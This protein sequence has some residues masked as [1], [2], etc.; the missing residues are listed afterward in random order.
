MVGLLRQRRKQERRQPANDVGVVLSVV[1]VRG[2]GEGDGGD[3][4]EEEGRASGG[5]LG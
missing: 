2:D 5:R 4:E 3:T 1:G